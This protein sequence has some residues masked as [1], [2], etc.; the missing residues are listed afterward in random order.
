MAYAARRLT[1]RQ[2]Q[3]EAAA[4]AAAGSRHAP[5][6]AAVP[7]PTAW[8]QMHGGSAPMPA[9]APAVPQIV[10]PTL[11]RWRSITAHYGSAK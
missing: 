3:D 2:R 7:A 1:T 6:A 4:T 9:A 8:R 10:D 5:I 11:H